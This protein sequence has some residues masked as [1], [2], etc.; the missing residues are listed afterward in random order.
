MATGYSDWAGM[1][2]GAV[3]SD[4]APTGITGFTWAG[5]GGSAGYWR[6]EIVSATGAPAGKACRILQYNAG[7]GSAHVALYV[8]AL[9]SLA[10]GTAA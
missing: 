6:A 10:A 4:S 2:V 8:A 1:S 9:G 7:W 3:A 5:P